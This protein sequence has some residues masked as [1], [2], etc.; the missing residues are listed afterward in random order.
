MLTKFKIESDD[1]WVR[2]LGVMVFNAT[3]KNISVISWRSVLLVE[4][5]YRSFYS[6]VRW[7]SVIFFI[8]YHKH[9]RSNFLWAIPLKRKLSTRKAVKKLTYTT[10]TGLSSPKWYG[11]WIYN[12]LLTKF[13][14]ESDDC[15]V[16]GLG[17]MVFNATFKN[18]SVI[19]WRSVLLVEETRRPRENHRL[20][21]SHWQSLSH[22]VSLLALSGSR[23]HI[24]GDRHQL[25]R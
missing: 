9:I 10:I 23:I 2:G 5:M 20:G 1:C 21:A 12:Y 4:E 3:F 22:N 7:V 24:S 13:K 16:R 17:V 6:Q 18:I 15:W 8:H 19:S 14:I 25:H 11:S